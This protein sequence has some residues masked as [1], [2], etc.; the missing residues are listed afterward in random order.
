M[1]TSK[2][3]ILWTHTFDPKISGSGNFMYNFQKNITSSTFEI[4]F[5]YLGK[6]NN[7]F[8]LFRAIIKLK[9]C[10]NNFDIIHAQFGSMCGFITSFSSKNKIITLRG[11]DW[12]IYKGNDLK[13]KIHAYIA[14]FFTKISLAKFNEIIVMSNRMKIEIEHKFP[15]KKLS[16]VTDPI[17]NQIFKPINKEFARR[18]Y[19]NTNS[20]SPWI[21]ITTLS[22]SNPIKRIDIAMRA[23]EIV[24]EII[25]NIELKIAT[26]V[27]Y[28]EMPFFVSS[29]DLVLCT[30]T[31]EGWPN[32]IKESLA[33]NIPFISTDVSDL[34]IIA[35]KYKSC[36]ISIDT[37]EKISE[38]IIDSLNFK[39]HENLSE[40]ISDFSIPVAVKKL[41]NIYLNI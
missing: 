34:S 37:P 33:C 19:F 18:Y 17:D 12:H 5:L 1:N 39:Q 30:S 26:N 25:P 23:V 14:Y 32:F 29:C 35:N 36:K 10:E 27:P 13:E 22:K 15:Y 21:L 16:I 20:K 7:P 8:N 40:C 41:Q 28:D 6:L 31:H 38:C 2:I 3:K 4:K 24:K 9:K 11:S